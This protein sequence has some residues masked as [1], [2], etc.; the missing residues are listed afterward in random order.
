MAERNCCSYINVLSNEA[1]EKELVR[2]A[3]LYRVSTNKQVDH[4]DE[5][6]VDI[7]VQRIACHEETSVDKG[8]KQ[9]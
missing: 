9:C 5:N 8:V 4:N 3:C 2:V 1:R 6:R 7:P